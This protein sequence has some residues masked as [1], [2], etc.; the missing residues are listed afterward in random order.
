MSVDLEVRRP[1]DDERSP[2]K[3]RTEGTAP[4]R[5]RHHAADVRPVAVHDERPP[6]EQ[7]DER[8]HR[9]VEAAIAQPRRRRASAVP[10]RI[11]SRRATEPTFQGHRRAALGLGGS[12]RSIVSPRRRCAAC[13]VLATQM[14]SLT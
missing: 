14:M 13:R 9:V 7:T 5:S 2:K 8:L 4:E 3:Q 12:M 1:V 11:G 10:A 6:A